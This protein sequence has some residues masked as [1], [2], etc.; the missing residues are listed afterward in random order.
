VLF[1]QKVGCRVVRPKV[2]QVTV[3]L[4]L[5]SLCRLWRLRWDQLGARSSLSKGGPDDAVRRRCVRSRVSNG[6]ELVLGTCR[7]MEPHHL[8]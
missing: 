7:M 6:L 2:T 3:C 1:S 4:Q 8:V 5:S